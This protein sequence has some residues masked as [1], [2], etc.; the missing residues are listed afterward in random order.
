MAQFSI[1][2]EALDKIGELE[3]GNKSK[4]RFKVEQVEEISAEER[5]NSWSDKMLSHAA[6]RVNKKNFHS[7]LRNKKKTN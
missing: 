7:F 3:N 2:G 5:R 4:S 6:K 1:S